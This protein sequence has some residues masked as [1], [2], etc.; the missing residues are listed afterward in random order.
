MKAEYTT[1]GPIPYEVIAAVEMALD[2]PKS[3][4]VTVAVV[5]SPV[6]PSDVLTLTGE[7]GMLPDLPAIGGNEGV[8]RIV[9]LG[10]E[11]HGLS[12]GDLVLLPLGSG[13]WRTHMTARA[14]SLFVL[15]ANADPLQMSMLAVNPPTASLLLSEFV[16]LAPGEW[17]IQNAAN[18]AVGGYLTQIAAARNL[19]TINVV[20][21]NDAMP[22]VE[23]VGGDGTIVDGPGLRKRVA[24]ITHGSPIRLAVDAV[25]G[26]ATGRL[27]STLSKGGVAV[28]YGSMSGEPAT[29]S[30]A[31]LIFAG[32]TLRG[33]WLARWFETA[34]PATRMALFG[35]IAEMI[36]AGSLS[37]S[38]VATYG[39][40]RIKDAV[41]HAAR[42][43]RDGK[44][45]IVPDAA[46]RL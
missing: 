11:V 2:P 39:V 25:G 21:R 27:C 34:E 43:S 18:S 35:E 19:R 40:E 12:V 31:S 30:A 24:D 32:V 8:G 9:D 3:D 28:A 7:Y 41:E 5:A 44:V 45:L 38:V 36:A 10:S 29:I 26:S 46:D 4:E 13:T 33:F 20:R 16:D 6:N 14:S 42:N 23:A 15:P 37:A 17:V 22:A 1:R